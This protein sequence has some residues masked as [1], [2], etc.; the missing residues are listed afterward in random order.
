VIAFLG[1]HLGHIDQVLN[2]A[3]IFAFVITALLT[4]ALFKHADML[5]SR[6]ASTLGY[7]GMKSP[8]R[9]A[10][11]GEESYHLALL[12]FHRM[13]SSLL[14]EIKS[15]YPYLLTK[16]LVVDFNVG[17]HRKIAEWGPTVKYGDLGN[18]ETLQQAGI[19][20]SRVI[21]CTIPD[22]LLVGTS[23]RRL[24]EAVRGINPD[25]V[26]I[27]NAITLS[28]SRHLYD[29]GANYVFLPR[30]E[31]AKAMNEAIYMALA[32]E[33]TRHRSDMREIHGA[34]R[35]RVEVFD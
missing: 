34:L 24:V 33:I 11:E 27:A 5:H 25:A 10:G 13:A 31:A 21:V 7:L 26:I 19:E 23:N 35:T 30:I 1:V 9:G 32:G 14:H 15:D 22:D 18:I 20:K 28:E 6:L 2:S 4:P 12:G 8:K 29:A 16:T 3:L 17:I